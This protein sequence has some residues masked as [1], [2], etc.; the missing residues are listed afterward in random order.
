MDIKQFFDNS[1]LNFEAIQN[2][3][4][5]LDDAGFVELKEDESWKLEAKKKYYVIKNDTSILAFRMGE[6][7]KKGFTIAASHSDSPGFRI[8]PNPEIVKEDVVVLNTEVYGG[9]L[10]S[11]WF[12]RPLSI[13]GKVTVD[14][15]DPLNPKVIKYLS[16]ENIVFIPSVAIHMNREANKG[17]EINPQ[18]HTLPIVG[19]NKDFKLIPYIEKE[20][21]EK[22]I[23][24]ELYL[25]CNSKFEYVGVDQE[26]FMTGRID[27]LA[28][29]FANINAIINA[30]EGTK[31]AVAYVSDNEEIG[32]MTAQGAFA[33]FFRET[34]ERIVVASGGNFEDYRIALKN[35]FMISSDQA[36]AVHPNFASYADPT[37]RPRMN[38]GPVIKIA[39]NGAYTSDANSIAVFRNLA[40][41]AGVKTQTFVN[42]SDKRGGSTIASI[43]TSKVDIPIVD[44]GNPVWGMHSA[45]E[46][47]AVKDQEAME[48]IMQVLFEQ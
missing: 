5:M 32:S 29:A 48:K 41:I 6:D 38:E 3:A 33:P 15:G 47:A 40:K 16:K 37:N 34:L 39:A 23:S 36:H 22:I 1:R 42:R 14:T 21:G 20:I 12:D 4:K 9:P 27:N 26:F 45:V 35:S 43:T 8:K 13:G 44:V 11:T 31:T 46:T 18:E 17:W 24:H 30:K 28:M 19:L 10:L 25:I 2:L 7:V